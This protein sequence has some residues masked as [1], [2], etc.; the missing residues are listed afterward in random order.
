MATSAR[1]NVSD[2][3]VWGIARTQNAFLVK[4]KCAGGVQFSR[5]PLNLVN[6]HSRKYAG[7]VNSKAIGVQGAE[8]GGV[9]VIS[10]RPNNCNKPGSNTYTATHGSGSSNRKVYKAVASRA[11][12]G[13][14]RADLRAEAVSRASA[15]RLSQRP[16][17][18]SPEKKLRGAKAR[19]AAAEKEA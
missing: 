17:K 13:G 6:K 18:D 15:I 2:D 19:K 8:N 3:L 11:V 7:F 14:Y 12:S 10:K 16:K 9:A 4:R 5:D 1:P